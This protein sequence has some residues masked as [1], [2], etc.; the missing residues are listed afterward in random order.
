MTDENIL[1]LSNTTE[2]NAAI[3]DGRYLLGEKAVEYI[4]NQMPRNPAAVQDVLG[5]RQQ[6][7]E[8]QKFVIRKEGLVKGPYYATEDEKDNDI[9]TEG[10]GGVGKFRPKRGENF[11]QAFLRA[12]DA[13]ETK[14]R[15]LFD[16]YDTFSPELQTQIM[17]GVYRG[18]FTAGNNTVTAIN[19][20]DFRTASE[21]FLKNSTQLLGWVP[22]GYGLT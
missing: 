16:N 1:D 13:K 4:Q 22:R 21:Q 10:V 6:L 7:T 12:F 15:E 14:A 19:K 9:V 20:G 18:D 17:S 5:L 8:A 11:A 2:Q 3:Q